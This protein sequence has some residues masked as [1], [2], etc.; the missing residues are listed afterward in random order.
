[1]AIRL[2][3]FVAKLPKKEQKAIKKRSAEL[4][5]EEATLRQLREARERSQVEMA[6]KLHINQA[7]VSKLERRTDM[8]LST[9][10]S[11]IEAMGGKLEIVARFPNQAIRITQFE[12]L[13]LEQPP[14]G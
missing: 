2:D 1:M 5:A 6:E 13:D 10:R 11:F 14:Q 9:L 3:D 7:S 8:Y 12:M 4:I